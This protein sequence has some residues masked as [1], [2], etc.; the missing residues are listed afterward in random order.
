VSKSENKSKSIGR[1]VRTNS[2]GSRNPTGIMFSPTLF[3]I[4]L[5]E[6]VNRFFERKGGVA[7]GVR[8]SKALDLQMIWFFLETMRYHLNQKYGMK[9]KRK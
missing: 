3:N 5:E 1:L 9:I 6:S 2:N 4:Y 7:I 8:K